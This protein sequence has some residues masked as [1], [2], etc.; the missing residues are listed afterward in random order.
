MRNLILIDNNKDDLQFMKEA[1]ASA[2]ASI[3]CVSFIFS[4]EAIRAMVNKVVERPQAVFMNL[5]MPYRNGV[6]CLM[7]LRS[8]AAFSNLPVILYAPKIT[9]EVKEALKGSGNTLFFEKP[10]TIMGWKKVM[11]Q[12]LSSVYHPEGHLKMYHAD[13]SGWSISYI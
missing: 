12:M 13:S 6:Q 1:L 9:F 10:K 2:D 3:Q 7:E 8:S 5:N 4:E 11:R